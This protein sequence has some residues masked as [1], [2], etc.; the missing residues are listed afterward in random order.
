MA[1][2]QFP[3]TKH[4]ER[5]FK[6]LLDLREIWLRLQSNSHVASGLALSLGLWA[7]AHFALVLVH[8]S[9]AAAL[10]A[11]MSAS[12]HLPQNT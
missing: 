7:L 12:V 4:F 10:A 9:G 5:G 2:P 6:S 11:L 1:K 3:T 8:V